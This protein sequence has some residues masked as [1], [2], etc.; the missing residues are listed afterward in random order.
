M[1]EFLFPRRKRDQNA[2]WGASHRRREQVPSGSSSFSPGPPEF[3]GGPIPGGCRSLSG[4]GET[5]TAPATAPL[6]LPLQN[7]DGLDS[8]TKRA[9]LIAQ[10]LI[11][12]E[13]NRRA[14]LESRPSPIHGNG[15]VRRTPPPAILWFLSHRWERNSPSR[16]KPSSWNETLMKKRRAGARCAPLRR[17]KEITAEENGILRADHPQNPQKPPQLF[18]VLRSN[19][20]QKTGFVT[21]MLQ[22]YGFVT[23]RPN[24]LT[25]G[26]H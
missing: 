22:Y 23:L 3:T 5:T 16:A 21:I 7:Q 25:G 14:G 18:P 19:I 10:G 20:S 9:R 8:W 26:L 12:A 1:G 13:E 24:P 17:L 2:A 11:S 6:P 4:A 15:S